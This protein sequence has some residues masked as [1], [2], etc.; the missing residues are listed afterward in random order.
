MGPPASTLIAAGDP[1]LND[2][3]WQSETDVMFSPVCHPAEHV[4]DFIG[5][6]RQRQAQRHE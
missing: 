1:V 2:V 6:W 3:R 4:F 5:S